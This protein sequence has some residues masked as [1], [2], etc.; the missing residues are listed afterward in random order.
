[1]NESGESYGRVVPEKPPNKAARV[2]AEVVEERRPA[3]GNTVSKTCA[4]PRAGGSTPSELARVRQVAERDKDARFTA[5]LHHVS[6]DRL[7]D[8]FGALRPRAAAGVDGVTWHAYEQNL[9]DNL[10]DL[11]ARV[12]RGGYRAK[13]S[14]RVYI[15]KADGRQR[16]LGIAALEDKIVQRAVVEVSNAIY[17]EDFLGFSNGFR[18][19]R[20]QHNALDALA[21]GI[22][23][24]K[25]NWMLDCDVADF[26]TRIDHSWMERFSSIASRTS[27][28]SG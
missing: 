24:K 19:R 13:P 26:F 18:P 8:A 16:P 23:R 7:R 21:A 2:A 5:L 28:C 27:G 9:E 15:P 20:S 17:E 3:K 25:V 22:Y 6:V 14:R 1:M 10:R 11:H 12:Q 4:G